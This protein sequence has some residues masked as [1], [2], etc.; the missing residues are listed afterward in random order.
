MKLESTLILTEKKHSSNSFS[1]LNLRLL[2]RVVQYF[3]HLLSPTRNKQGPLTPCLKMFKH[4]SGKCQKRLWLSGKRHF[5]GK[6]GSTFLSYRP[7]KSAQKPNLKNRNKK[8]IARV[9]VLN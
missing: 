3:K 2:K 4:F 5:S 7:T 6:A 9:Q 8:I 1:V